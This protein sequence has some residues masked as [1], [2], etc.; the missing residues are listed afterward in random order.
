MKANSS[1]AKGLAVPAVATRRSSLLASSEPLSID[2][3]AKETEGDR[4]GQT[5]SSEDVMVR[6]SS[7]FSKRGSTDSDF[8]AVCGSTG[9]L[10]AAA[11]AGGFQKLKA[12][13]ILKK[14]AR[15]SM[16]NVATQSFSSNSSSRDSSVNYLH[17]SE[18]STSSLLEPGVRF[19]PGDMNGRKVVKD[20]LDCLT[21]VEFGNDKQSL[22]S[23][24]LSNNSSSRSPSS[25]SA[26]S[27]SSSDLET[28]APSKDFASS[29]S[30]SFSRNKPVAGDG[31]GPTLID[32]KM[33][34]LNGPDLAI[35]PLE[36]PER[37]YPETR[38]ALS[39]LKKEFLSA[40]PDSPSSGDYSA[41][42]E[43]ISVRVSSKRR[44]SGG[45]PMA[46]EAST[47][48]L[49]KSAHF[50]ESGSTD[51]LSAPRT[52]LRAADILAK[53]SQDSLA[54]NSSRNSVISGQ[55]SPLAESKRNSVLSSDV[56]SRPSSGD[57]RVASPK[58][59]V[60]ASS[61]SSPKSRPTSL[62]STESMSD[63][64]T[65]DVK[66]RTSGLVISDAFPID[67]AAQLDDLKRDSSSDIPGSESSAVPVRNSAATKLTASNICRRLAQDSMDNLNLQITENQSNESINTTSSTDSL[68]RPIA[69]KLKAI[70]IYSKIRKDS[71]TGAEREGPVVGQTSVDS[72]MDNEELQEFTPPKV[73]PVSKET[74]GKKPL[75]G[76]LRKESSS[77]PLLG[78]SLDL[79]AIRS[80]SA[81]SLVSDFGFERQSKVKWIKSLVSE[82]KIFRK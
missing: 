72:E 34:F 2:D 45:K 40:F 70:D 15:D 82:V 74:I 39:D 54:S 6:N 62:L 27:V 17:S 14:I 71:L 37:A 81:D 42:T 8:Q 67:Q 66:R 3:S 57:S 22:D 7:S 19:R 43:N 47:S 52:K 30:P 20:S 16:D 60:R 38:P 55:R 58:A 48:S 50:N 65:V 36:T 21:K 4:V 33:E 9:S 61:I 68:S 64:G 11:A 51:S 26:I 31:T 13:D 23:I 35:K 41:S 80:E 1:P 49:G 77:I 32:L 78:S 56:I 46:A 28:C 24:D 79:K 29:R 12:A 44:L 53:M 73:V 59:P 75:K 18:N 76:I 5:S 63:N 10:A 25:E 69:A